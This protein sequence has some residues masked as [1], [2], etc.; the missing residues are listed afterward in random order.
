M[1]ASGFLGSHVARR[2]VARDID[3]RVWVRPSSASRPFDDLP[4][5]VHRGE[6]HDADALRAAMEDV[7]T[8]HYCIVD[9]RAWLRDPAPLFATNVEALRH[10]LDAALESDVRRFV[11]CSTVGTIGVVDD[12]L[13][14]ESTP[15]TWAHLGGPYIRSRIEAEELVLDHVER[16]GLPAIVMCVGTTY[17]APDFGSPHGRM[18]AEA[19][20]GRLPVYF[21]GAA[22]EV[23]GVADAA[24]AFV[25]A[26][27]RGR[28]GE[29]YIISESFM[30]WQ[31][32]VTVAAEAVGA[33]PPRVGIPLPVMKAVGVVGDGLGRLLRRDVVMNRVSVRLM[34]FMSPLD[35]GKAGRELGWHPSPTREAIAAAARF[36]VEQDPAP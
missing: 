35:H 33:R 21:A 25:L 22:M 31:E 2:L 12:G 29:R 6:L 3:T 5:E 15:N 18:V 32:L 24:E 27:E 10:V 4:V 9:T 26:A 14:D 36:H 8:V 16:R 13:A 30:T 19:A 1:G 23:V 7:D 17:G 34:H 20:R 28:V 11:F